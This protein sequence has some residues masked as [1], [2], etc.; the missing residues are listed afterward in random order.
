M[1]E[2]KGAKFTYEKTPLDM[3]TTKTGKY[4]PVSDSCNKDGDPE[5][6]CVYTDALFYQTYASVSSSSSY[7]TITLMADNEELVSRKF[8]NQQ[9]T[10]YTASELGCTKDKS[11]CSSKCHNKGGEWNSSSQQC[12]V[13]TYLSSVCYRVK[14]VGSSYKLDV[15]P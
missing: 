14:K 10:Y 12:T 1:E 13:H 6:K 9:T 4:Y 7:T 2:F 8:A 15:P 11:K 3:M 5:E